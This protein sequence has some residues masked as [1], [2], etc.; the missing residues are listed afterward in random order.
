MAVQVGAEEGRLGRSR[1]RLG[2]W[3]RIIGRVKLGLLEFVEFEKEE[4]WV[5]RGGYL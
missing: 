2:Q 1:E 4:S 3:T 5:G